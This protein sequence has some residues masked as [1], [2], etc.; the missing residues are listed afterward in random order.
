MMR[1]SKVISAVA[2]RRQR[3]TLESLTPRVYDDVPA[4]RH[5]WA[6]LTLEAHLI[7][8]LNEK[9][10]DRDGAIWSLRQE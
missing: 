3:A 2:C 4:D 1:E 8:L 10:V 5:Q 6:Q 9:R 7:K